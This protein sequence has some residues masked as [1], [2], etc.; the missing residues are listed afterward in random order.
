MFSWNRLSRGVKAVFF[1]Q[2]VNR[3]GD[4]V[5]PFLTLLMTQVYGLG[6]APA[7]LVVTAAMGLES[8]GGLVAGRLSDRHGRRQVLVAFL[9]ISA[10][11]LAGAG[12]APA[13]V[14]SAVAIVA[15]GFFVGAMR[16]VLAALVADL[17]A[18][19]LR[20]AAF[21]LS[22]L[23]INLGVSVGP[24]LAGWLFH[25]ALSWLF[26]VDALSTAAALIILVANVPRRTNPVHAAEPAA[27]RE[28][29][30]FS[31]FM[32]NPVLFP[33]ALLAATYNV[34]YAQMIF[35][36]GL[37]TVRL[38]GLQGPQV[39]GTVWTINALS[40]LGLT[41]LALRVTR[42]WS[43]LKSISVGMGFFALGTSVFLFGP[44]LALVLAS[45]VL[46]TTGEVLY[47]IHVGDLVSTYSPPSVRGRF[48]GYVQFLATMGFVVSPA[49]GGLVAQALGLTGVWWLATALVAS[50]GVG[51]AA[52][53]R[54]A[55]TVAPLA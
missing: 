18:P 13:S 5:F 31:A 19:E 50:A 37:Q 21:S 4:F 52:V 43:N 28:A 55:R 29:G 53:N 2:I 35:T 22:Y 26:W 49:A 32:R 1:V 24:L 14:V 27:Q 12:V 33:F 48:Q 8:I 10:L 51:F 38:F 39:Y 17:S 42:R 46:W 30:S 7:G 20:R 45:T 36:L 9:S 23:G 34:V 44:G 47:S 40:V 41:P 6:P 11:L 15:S 3:M 16:P 25:H 54:R